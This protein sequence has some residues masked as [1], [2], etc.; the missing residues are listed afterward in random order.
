M[1][2]KDLKI[3]I[4]QI[5]REIT[6]PQCKK[7]YLDEEIE[8]IG[9]PDGEQCYF[10]AFCPKCESDS[11]IHVTLEPHPSKLPHLGA[12]PRLG[13]ISQN[14]V[15]DMHNFLREFDGNFETLFK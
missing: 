13:Q 15:L 10:S 8:I 9:S 11:I 4:K 1:N 6:C 5:K 12:A 3:I 14:E 7:K 2:F